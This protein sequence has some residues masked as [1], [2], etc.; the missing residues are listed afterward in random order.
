ML[1]HHKKSTICFVYIKIFP[2]RETQTVVFMA[3]K[4]LQILLRTRAWKC[5]LSGQLREK[6]FSYHGKLSSSCQGERRQPGPVAAIGP[7]D[8]QAQPVASTGPGLYLHHRGVGNALRTPERHICLF[9]TNERRSPLRQTC[10][11]VFS[12][13]FYGSA[14]LEA[15]VTVFTRGC[16][17]AYLGILHIQYMDASVCICV[18][19]VQQ[20]AITPTSTENHYREQYN[21]CIYMYIHILYIKFQLKYLHIQFL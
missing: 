14:L 6:S 12:Y 20:T 13:P 17:G 2:L 18:M 1:T 7:D 4:R 9:S 10:T 11:S 5:W 21:I 8:A 16:Y 3:A 19:C 15:F